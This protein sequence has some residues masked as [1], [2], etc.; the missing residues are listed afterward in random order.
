MKNTGR[1][2]ALAALVG[3]NA[4]AAS[5]MAI[6]DNA[7]LFLTGS[8]AI[9]F[10]DN[11]YLDQAN[12]QDDMIWS[13]APGFDVVF[14]QGSATQGNIY[15]REEFL[16]Y[17][18]ASNQDTSLSNVG[19]KTRYDGGKSKFDLGFTYNQLSQNDNDVRATGDLVRRELTHFHAS[20]EFGIT[21]KSSLAIGVTYDRTNYKP[22]GYIDNSV[23]SV[24]VDYYFEYSPKL[25]LS[26]GYRRRES[27]LGS[28]GIDSE[29]NFFNIGARG[30]FTPK[31]TGQLRVGFGMRE[32]DTGGDDD[33]IGIDGSLA[34][35][36]SS[37]TSYRF[38]LSNDFGSSASGD[39]TKNFALGLTAVSQVTQQMSWNAGLNYRAIEYSTR[40]DDYFE[41]QIGLNYVYNTY[42]NFG[43]SFTHRKNDSTTGGLDFSNNV[44]SFGANVRY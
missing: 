7:E 43:A 18:D 29:D 31:V 22:N 13:F 11:I 38:T 2:L 28:G 20:P 34:F 15:Y 42:L 3:A 36:A 30:E 27:D 26:V 24:P 4:Q 16:K 6:G 5:F 21:E 8:A 41:G 33:Q 14:G 1:I 9:R 23:W 40:E 32:F 37:K 39:S 10:D 12:E 19:I 35:E 44:F 25:D 17:S